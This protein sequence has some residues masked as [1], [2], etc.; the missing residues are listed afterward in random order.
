MRIHTVRNLEC[1]AARNSVHITQSFA[2]NK[3][4]QIIFI[5]KFTLEINRKLYCMCVKSHTL[6]KKPAYKP[7]IGR[8]YTSV[9]AFSPL[10]P[11]VC[12]PAL[13]DTLFP[14]FFLNGPELVDDLGEVQLAHVQILFGAGG[15]SVQLVQPGQII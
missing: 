10:G 7:K 13:A 14:R 11:P 4:L 3:Y 1:L 2:Q 15:F 9:N 12:L 8:S 6:V 5:L